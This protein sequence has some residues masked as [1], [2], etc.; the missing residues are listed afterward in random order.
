LDLFAP[1]VGITSAWYSSDLAAAT[2]DGTSMAA[3]HV[4]GVA[5]LFLQKVPAAT[6]AQV[7]QALTT[8]AT[9]N[10]V[11]NPGASS[12]N[13]LLYSAFLNSLLAKAN[14]PY[15]GNEGAAMTFSSAG[16]ADPEGGTLTYLWTFGD[17]TS[18]TAA[19]PTH[20]YADNGTYT[21]ALTV[22]TAAGANATASTTATVANVAPTATFRSD[23]AVVGQP[24]ALRL[25]GGT[26]GGSV[27]LATLQYAFDCG[28]GTGFAAWSSVASVTCAASAKPETLIVRGKVRDKD[29]GET[30]Y[31][32]ALTVRPPDSFTQYLNA[33]PTGAIN[34]G[35]QWAVGDF[36]GDR[37]A[38]VLFW[39]RSSGTNRL[40]L[41]NADGSFTQRLDPIGT[42]GINAGDQWAVGDFNGDGRA[43]VLFWWKSSGTNRL[44]LSNP[45][46]SF[47]QR[48]D[49]VPVGAINGGDQ[50]TVGDFNGDGRADVLYWWRASGTN[51]LYLS[52]GDGSFAQRLD[53]IGAGAINGGDQW[54][55]GDFNGDR[56]TDVLFWW[57]SSGTNRLYLSNGDGSFAQRLDPISVGAING[58]DRWIVGDFNGD[59]RADV[60]FWWKA[61]GTNR[62]YLADAVGTFTQS[63]NPI[64]TAAVNGGDE[65]TVGDFNGDGRADVLFWWKSLGTN[66][67][68]LANAT[69]TF[70]PSLDPIPTSAINGGDQWAVG[71]VNGDG[72]TDVVFW[73]K[74]SGTNRLYVR[75]NDLGM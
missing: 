44:Y 72:R 31:Q 12:P 39:W 60:L 43:D 57:R 11:T 6:P 61:A 52:N 53:P 15:T 18:S 71:D 51:R 68:Y 63:L 36:N 5:A 28:A 30:A 7:A 66:R 34:G 38:D 67:L 35:D 70:A 1:G 26:D 37:R 75:R 22:R 29:G 19:N 20:A 2:L 40:Y 59:R 42:T 9:L 69:G 13:R 32:H 64:A 21:V 48:L 47:T 65:W 46:A 54:T 10:V 58:G 50:W 73:W 23:T 62:L 17:G 45:D 27:D 24:H 14:G 33:M 3:P 55:V 8:N 41:A 74:A 25:A 16:S 49:P 56:R 4:A